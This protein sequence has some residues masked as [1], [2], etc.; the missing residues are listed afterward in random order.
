[1]IV[2]QR[3]KLDYYQ[4]NEKFLKD[5]L[6]AR[7]DHIIGL[8]KENQALLVDKKSLTDNLI[9]FKSKSKAAMANA[10]ASTKVVI[11]EDQLK[12]RSAFE[13]QIITKLQDVSQK[14]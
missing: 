4:T 9:A 1:M 2:S 13:H 7:E 14:F 12:Q 3:E 5:E 10:D 6:K 11:L 8:Q